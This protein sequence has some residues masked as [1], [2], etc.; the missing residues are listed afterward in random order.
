MSTTQN[1]PTVEALLTRMGDLERE[2]ATLRAE[3]PVA[4][5]PTSTHIQNRAVERRAEPGEAPAPIQ[6]R[7]RRGLLRAAL[8]SGATVIGAGALLGRGTGVAHANGNEGPTVFTSTDGTTP[9]VTATGS[10]GSEGIYATSDSGTAIAAF[11]ST[12]GSGVF[13]QSNSGYGLYGASNSGSGVYASGTTGYGVEGGSTS[14][15]GVYGFSNKQYGMHAVGGG[16]TQTSGPGAAGVFAEGGPNYGVYATST[17]GTGVFGRSTS[18]YGVE[19][20]SSTGIGVAGGSTSGTGVYA[21]SSSG[22]AL[23]ANGHVQVQGNAVGQATLLAGHSSVTVTTSAATASSNILL[24]PLA[25]PKANLWVTRAAGSFTIH[26][27]AAPTSN[28]SIAYL[29]IN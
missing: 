2:L 12:N 3:R 26:A 11:A 29:I 20:F 15:T 13:G 18:S 24:T 17:T 28:L 16:A 5:S 8:V 27:S 25:N 14:G 7:S 4:G 22:P 10:N 9:A 23:V 1:E 21:Q 19:G 6:R